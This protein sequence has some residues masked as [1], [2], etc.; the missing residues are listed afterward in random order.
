MSLRDTLARLEKQGELVRVRREVD[1]T[2][3]LAAV[4]RKLDGGPAVLFENVR[5]ATMPVVVGTDGTKERVARNLGVKTADLIARFGRAIG[6]PIPWKPVEDGPVRTRR[7]QP[8]FDIGAVLPVPHHYEKE[9]GPFI[10]GGMVVARDPDSGA[11]NASYNR[12]QVKGGTRCGIY[13]QPRHLLQIHAKNAAKSRPT[14][15]AVIFGM[16]TAVRLASATWG[17]NIPLELDEFAIAGGLR[18]RAVEMVP[19]ETCD[20][21]VPADAEIVLEGRIHPDALEPEGPMAE[22]TGVYGGADP[23]H[24]FEATGLLMREDPI[25]QDIVPF[26]TEHHLMLGLPYEGVLHRYV[27]AQVPGLVDVH[28]TPGGC[29]KFLAVLAL[30]KRHDGDAKNAIL[31]AFGAIRDIKIVMAVDPDIDIGNPRE[32]QFA[33]ATRVQGD[34]DIFMIPRAKGNELDPIQD[35]YG[36]IT[37]IGIDATKPL[38]RAERFELARIPGYDTLD[39]RDYLSSEE[40]RR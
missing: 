13:I 39:L 3:E 29:G 6:E 4:A 31:G 11:L 7:V 38:A 33:L 8:P 20:L 16:D 23:K 40:A 36:H 14:D 35:V 26:G 2:F 30:E 9:P 32:V 19:C 10:T 28:L 17:S 5:G 37:K 34:E 25:Y 1:R 12:M 24:V 15:V 18:G 21:R 22:F 27:K